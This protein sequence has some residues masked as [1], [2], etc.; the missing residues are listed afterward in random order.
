MRD[1]SPVCHPWLSALKPFKRSQI[2]IGKDRVVWKSNL[3]ILTTEMNVEKIL[4][5]IERVGKL[6]AP[7]TPKLVF[8]FADISEYRKVQSS[9]NRSGVKYE[10]FT[11]DLMITAAK[12][13]RVF[14]KEWVITAS[15]CAE[16]MIF[17]NLE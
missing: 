7:F 15:T 12:G 14:F 6:V 13:I 11:K 8:S 9:M 5:K 4:E 17:L 16:P 3:L 1:L 10:E 2:K